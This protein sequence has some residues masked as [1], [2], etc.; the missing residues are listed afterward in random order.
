MQIENFFDRCA[1]FTPLLTRLI[2]LPFAPSVK[3]GFSDFQYPAQFAD[4]I[5]VSVFVNE[6]IFIYPL[7]EKMSAAFFK[8]SFSIS[9]SIMRFLIVNF[10]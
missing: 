2:S 6:L 9:S 1:K 10:S 7:L 8:M 4:R 3:G 5:L